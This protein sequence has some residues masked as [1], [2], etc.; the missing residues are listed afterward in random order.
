[1]DSTGTSGSLDSQTNLTEHATR[2]GLGVHISFVRSL[3]M[4]KWND[5]QVKKMQQGG[6][7]KAKA[8]FLEHG[9]DKSNSI[10]DVYNSHFAAMYRDKVKGFRFF[11]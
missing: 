1:M 6:N 10:P 4:D 5:L 8:F 9:Y 7:A 2:R 3:T 11:Q